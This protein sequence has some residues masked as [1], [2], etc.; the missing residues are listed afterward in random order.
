MPISCDRTAYKACAFSLELPFNL[1]HSEW[2]RWQ[3][4]IGGG[5][6]GDVTTRCGS[7]AAPAGGISTAGREGQMGGG[8]VSREKTRL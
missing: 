3:E 6:G 4:P 8:E 2:L 7:A 1:E 5:V